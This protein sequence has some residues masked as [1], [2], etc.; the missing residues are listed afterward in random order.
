MRYAKF[1]IPLAL[2]IIL[3]GCDFF[4]DQGA[5]YHPFK[6]EISKHEF[7]LDLQLDNPWEEKGLGYINV[8]RTDTMWHLWYESFGENSSSYGRFDYNSYFNYAYSSDGVKWIKPNL[9]Y[10]EYGDFKETNILISNNGVSNKGIHGMT[11]FLDLNSSMSEGSYKMVYTRWIDSLSS[12]WVYGMTSVNGLEWENERIIKRHYSDT[13]TNAYNYNGYYKLFYR[14]WNGEKHGE[15]YRQ[16]GVSAAQKF[17][18]SLGQDFRKISFENADVSE[19]HLY[20]N[21]TRVI[22]DEYEFMFPSIFDPYKDQMQLKIGYRKLENESIESYT[23]YKFEQEL[24]EDLPNFRVLYVA[25]QA[26]R[27]SEN[28]YLIY[29]SYKEEGHHSWQNE[30]ISFP[31]KI[32]RFHLEVITK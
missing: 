21:A 19:M 4:K 20:N 23:F 29:Y 14:Y 15:G 8:I 1:F 30:C 11:V 3:L 5:I 27:I 22:E 26:I 10:V 18:E 13:Q 17:D 32:G 25:P 12:N 6:L 7:P 31:G 28:K 9:E 24:F 2:S 16:I